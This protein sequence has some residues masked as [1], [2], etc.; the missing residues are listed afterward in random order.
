[1]D[2][3]RLKTKVT[4]GLPLSERERAKYLLFIASIDEMKEYLN[5]E[6]GVIK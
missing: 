1:M 2:K 3:E 6:K 4:L 5:K